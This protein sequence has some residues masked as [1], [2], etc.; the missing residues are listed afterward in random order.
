MRFLAAYPDELSELALALRA[1][2]LKVVPRYHE[3]VWDAV[4]AVSVVFTPTTRWQDGICHVATYTKHVNLGFNRGTQ[5]PDA[6][7]VLEGTG[8]LTRHA[9]F[10]TLAD[11]KAGWIDGYLRDAVRE[12]GART[13]DGDGGVSI[14]VMAGARRRP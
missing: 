4:N 2:V 6:D 11:A 7:G 13:T 10:R 14:R 12:A 8:K 3:V 5:L 9:S 1:R